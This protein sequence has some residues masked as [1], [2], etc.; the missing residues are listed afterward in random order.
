MQSDSLPH[1]YQSSFVKASISERF[2]VMIIGAQS[3]RCRMSKIACSR[4]IIGWLLVDTSSIQPQRNGSPSHAKNGL[5]SP[6][7]GARL[8]SGVTDFLHIVC[9]M[10]SQSAGSE[11]ANVVENRIGTLGP[12]K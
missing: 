11:P 7:V 9:G 4:S 2:G 1:V 5:K 12:H 6:D 10:C 8:V 3:S